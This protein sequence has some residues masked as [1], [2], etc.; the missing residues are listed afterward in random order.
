M[1]DPV[2]RA[3]VEADLPAITRLYA[4]WV[5]DACGTFELEPPT[6]AEMKAR[7]DYVRALG[8]PYLVAE[9]DGN[10]LGYAYA[11]PFRAREAYRYMVED[12]IYLSAEAHG[13][14]IGGALLDQLI[15]LCERAGARQM[16]AVIGDSANESSIRL[17]RSRGFADSGR[18]HAAGWKLEGWRDV[19]FMQR[20][21][22][23]GADTP[24]DQ[25]GLPLRDKA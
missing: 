11:G 3:A 6:E 14:G 4:G 18:F 20:P 2:I 7:F 17:H 24:P 9:R 1:S 22:G 21:L 10:V 15:L 25:P 19:I 8:M 5:N 23:Q 13:A 16:V 12:S